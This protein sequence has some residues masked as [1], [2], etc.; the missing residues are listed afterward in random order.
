MNTFCNAAIAAAV[1]NPDAIVASIDYEP[2]EEPEPPVEAA[3]AVTEL[4]ASKSSDAFDF[5]SL[6]KLGA[7]AKSCGVTDSQAHQLIG[8]FIDAVRSRLSLRESSVLICSFHRQ[9]E[10]VPRSICHLSMAATATI[11]TF[12]ERKSTIRNPL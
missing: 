12:A 7:I 10:V 9:V 4:A 2:S 8:L 3:Q 5:I 1:E 6:S 11:A